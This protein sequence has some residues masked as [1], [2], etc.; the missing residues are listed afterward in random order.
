MAIK[1]GSNTEQQIQ[2]F[3]RKWKIKEL[4]FFGSAVRDDFDPRHSDVDVLYT[5][6]PEARW[7]LKIVHAHKELERIL[8][9]KVDFVSKRAV[10]NSYNHYRKKNILSAYKVIYGQ[11]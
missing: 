7:G 4:A 6:A 1:I 8:G 5:F 9:R 3:C 11:T 2:S 10:E